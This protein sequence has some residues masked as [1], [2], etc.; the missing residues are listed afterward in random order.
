MRGPDL[1][2]R[3]HPCMMRSQMTHI[4]G[5]FF[6]RCYNDNVFFFAQLTG[7]NKR[8]HTYSPLFTSAPESPA[9]KGLDVTDNVSWKNPQYIVRSEQFEFYY[10]AVVLVVTDVHRHVVLYSDLDLLVGLNLSKWRIV[11]VKEKKQLA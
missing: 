11:G 2:F 5:Y 9:V 8:M 6:C 10:D 7:L 4:L 3:G 1:A